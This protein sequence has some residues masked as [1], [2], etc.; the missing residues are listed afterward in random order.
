MPIMVCLLRSYTFWPAPLSGSP[1]M[2]RA[3]DY[4]LSEPHQVIH[5]TTTNPFASIQTLKHADMEPLLFRH[6]CQSARQ[7]Q[8]C[9]LVG[10]TSCGPDQID[11]KLEPQAPLDYANTS[12]WKRTTGNL[13]AQWL[14]HRP[15]NLMQSSSTQADQATIR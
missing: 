1:G 3:K 13:E 9:T 5:S 6:T 8:L 14:W 12:H 2:L 10:K 4:A 15:I 11:A 7:H